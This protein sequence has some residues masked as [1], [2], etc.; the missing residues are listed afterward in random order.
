MGRRKQ[1]FKKALGLGVALIVGALLVSASG[2][3]TTRTQ[4]GTKI[5]VSTRAA[6]IQ[7]LRSIHVSAKGVVIQRGLRNYAGAQCPGKGW[8]CAGTRHTVVQ[9]AKRG[10]LNR[11]ACSTAKCIVV[12]FGRASGR[13][14]AASRALPAGYPSPQNLATCTKTSGITGSC[15]IN[16][17][18]TSGTNEAVVWMD[19]GLD[20]GL[21]QSATFSASITQGPVSVPTNNLASNWNLACVHQMVDIDG[22]A[23]KTNGA[24][25]TVNDNSHQSVSITQNSLSGNNAVQGAVSDGT[26][27]HPT[28]DC[29]TAGS[30]LTQSETLTS[31]VTTKGSVTQNQDAA[32]NG[33]NVLLDIE[34]NHSGGFQCTT[35]LNCPSS[36]TNNASFTQTSSQTAIANSGSGPVNQT[37]SSPDQIAPYSGLVGTINQDSSGP[38]TTV[39]LQQ[40]RQCEDAAKSGL[41]SCHRGDP[42]YAE[43]P[44][45]LNQTQYGPEGVFKAPA[46]GGHGP[47]HYAHKGYGQAT[48]TGNSGDS[49]TITQ[50]SH[51]ENDQGPGG[52]QFNTLEGDCFTPNVPADANPPGCTLHQTTD[53]NGTTTQNDQSGS[54]IEENITCSPG[55]PCGPGGHNGPICNAGNTNALYSDMP[56]DV[57]NCLNP[58]IGFQAQSTSEFGDQVGLKGGA[59]AKLGSLN[60]DFQSFAC[61]SGSW[62][63]DPNAGGPCSSAANATFQWP[64]TANIYAVSSVCPVGG[65]TTCPGTLLA[66]TTPTQT[67]PYRPSADTTGHCTGNVA[68]KWWNPDATGG[69]ACQ[70][71]IGTVLTF[72]N[73]TYKNGFDGT[74]PANVIWTVAFNTSSYGTNP[75]GTTGPYDSL[76]VGDNTLPGAP[77]A[78]TDTDP[79]GVV[80]NSLSS[81]NYCSDGATPGTLALATPCWNGLAPLGEIT[82]QVIG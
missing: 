25:V 76:N 77:Y 62:N 2:A 82:A 51:Q 59:G 71:S 12:Q 45:V 21:V 35:P 52:K 26:K 79:N 24:G 80:I 57:V 78:G 30:S 6:V 43:A 60:V 29:G 28:F 55:V 19:S 46:N 36:G 74:L 4:T 33:P 75:V 64:I 70:N 10:G 68:N 13:L 31:T 15:V 44:T 56:T 14:H 48:I 72:S 73:W 67:I 58:A 17:P 38:S 42:D 61:Q 5:N 22:S 81:G 63:A 50:T 1:V 20:S 53:L 18:N 32:A 54:D 47:V 11:F 65:P 16:Q 34:Q 69:G 3:A 49:I 37:Q 41:T 23:T 8:T 39:A 66:T 40:E 9:I 27:Q 7:Y